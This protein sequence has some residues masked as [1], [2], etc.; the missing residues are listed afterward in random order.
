MRTCLICRANKHQEKKH[1]PHLTSK[2]TPREK[3]TSYPLSVDRTHRYSFRV[4][5]LQV[6]VS[7]SLYFASLLALS[8]RMRRNSA[9]DIGALHE[10]SKRTPRK[11]ITAFS[12]ENIAELLCS[13]FIVHIGAVSLYSS[14]ARRAALSL[15]RVSLA[16]TLSLPSRTRHTREWP[17][18]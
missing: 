13:T 17:S 5:L 16:R 7:R 4:F 2:R 9:L 14:R 15:L 3:T 18:S 1:M 12:N 10:L 11:K 8:H 6:G